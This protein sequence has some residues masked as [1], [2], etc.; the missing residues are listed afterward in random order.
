MSE[1]VFQDFQN[2]INQFYKGNGPNT[3]IELGAY[4]WSLLSME[5]FNNSRRIAF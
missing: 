3:V 5:K 2:I 4:H 1:K